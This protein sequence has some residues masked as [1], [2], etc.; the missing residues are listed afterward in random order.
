MDVPAKDRKH[1]PADSTIFLSKDRL[2]GHSTRLSNFKVT[3]TR[4]GDRHSHP[5]D[6]LIF[7]QVV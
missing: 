5:E 2:C 6:R 4:F 7:I 1:R 3:N